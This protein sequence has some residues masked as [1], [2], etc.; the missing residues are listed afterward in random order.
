MENVLN[1]ITVKHLA[2]RA[3]VDRR[4]IARWQ[5]S[6]KLTKGIKLG[7]QTVWR[8]VDVQHLFTTN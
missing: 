2:L 8:I 6:E 1:V 3:G 7:L 4:T 5:K